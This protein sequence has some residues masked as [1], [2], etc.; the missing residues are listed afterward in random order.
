MK[1]LLAKGGAMIETGNSVARLVANAIAAADTT[2][3]EYHQAVEKLERDLKPRLATL[4]A[5]RTALLGGLSRATASEELT[6]RAAALLDDDVIPR[7][8]RDREAAQKDFDTVEDEIHVLRRALELQQGVVANTHR[9]WSEL[10]CQR[11]APSHREQVRRIADGIRV[12]SDALTE[13]GTFTEMLNDA[14]VSFTATLRPMPFAGDSLRLDREWSN[15]NLWMADAREA[16]LLDGPA[17][18]AA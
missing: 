6:A 17:R 4:E 13:H 16:G 10:V 9:R 3:P 1:T 2:C 18:S 8:A 5:R 12:L 14:G 15:A 7:P 11:L